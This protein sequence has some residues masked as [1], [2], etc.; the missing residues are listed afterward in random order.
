MAGDRLYRQGTA[1]LRAL[2]SGRKN[3]NAQAIG[4]GRRSTSD[5]RRT[6]ARTGSRR[7]NQ[8]RNRGALPDP[9]PSGSREILPEQ[10]QR[11][12]TV[13]QGDEEDQGVDSDREVRLIW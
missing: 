9:A 4:A 8:S 1:G 2:P 12:R 10:S 11:L 7:R 13:A 3:G 6:R 5:E